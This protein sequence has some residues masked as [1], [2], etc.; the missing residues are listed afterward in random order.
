MVVELG[1]VYQDSI[2]GIV[3][4]AMARCIYL[5]DVPSVRIEYLNDGKIVSAW[6]TE[7]RLLDPGDESEK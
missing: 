2:T 7:A 5:H 6:I 1:K 4:T 3:G